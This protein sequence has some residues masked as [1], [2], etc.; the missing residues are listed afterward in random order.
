MPLDITSFLVWCLATRGF[1]TAIIGIKPDILTFSPAKQ[2]LRTSGV[3][4]G[5][6]LAVWFWPTVMLK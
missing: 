5:L 6:S 3:A 2:T 4:G 1:P